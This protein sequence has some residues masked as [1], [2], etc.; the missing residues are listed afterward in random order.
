MT[1]VMQEIQEQPA[2]LER[3]LRGERATIERIRRLVRRRNFRVVVFI[4][5]GTSYNAALFGRYL[6]E[7]T[8]KH[9][10]SLA[11]P[12]VHILYRAQ[13]DL[14]GALAVGISQSGEGTD[15]NL[16]LEAYRKQGA[17]TVGITNHAKSTM[18]QL[19]DEVLLSHAGTERS[20]A[21]TKTYTTQLLLLYE[22]AWALGAS[23]RRQE[24]ERLP[25]LAAQA[26]R[27][28]GT[29]RETVQRYRSM[30]NCIV[31]GRGLNYANAYELALKLMETCYVIAERFSAADLLHGPIALVERGFRVFVFLPHGVT[32]RGLESLVRRLKQL[33]A[34]ILLFSDLGPLPP[35][36][37]ALVIP[38]RIPELWTPIPYIIPAQLFAALLAEAKGLNP[39]A[40]RHVKKITQTI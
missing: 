19:V 4:A 17:F 25:A 32:R 37:T 27:L 16:V 3:T 31:V 6:F 24:I 8:T 38:R 20:V 36:N 5:R 21:A 22:L 14:R 9:V 7:I 30:Q 35:A 39:D 23:F 13:L 29:V 28:E 11:A 18:A 1:L 12:S 2:A 15:V 40:P 10:A 34:D 33:G 26:L